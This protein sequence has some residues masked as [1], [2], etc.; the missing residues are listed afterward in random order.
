MGILEPIAV[1]GTDDVQSG[2]GPIE[3]EESQIEQ[4]SDNHGCDGERTKEPGELVLGVERDQGKVEG[5]REGGLELRE[6]HDE[7]L[8]LLGS[9]GE[10]VLQRCDGGEDLGNTDED[11]RSGNDPDVDW[12]RVGEPISGL[13]LGW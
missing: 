6:C 2:L 9:L 11:V 13:T 1:T 7:R 3:L 8:H 5:G 12:S 10:S 4:R